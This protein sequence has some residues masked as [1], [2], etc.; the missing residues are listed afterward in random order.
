M[1]KI[2][3]IRK[4]FVEKYKTLQLSD[5]ITDTI[6]IIG[7]QFIADAS[8]IFGNVNE[9]YLT[10]EIAW[11]K[12]QSL[13]VNDIP[14][15]P[16]IWTTVADPSGFINSNYG[17]CIFSS[18]NNYQYYNCLAELKENPN[19]RRATM[20]YNRPSMWD[21]YNKNGMS[22]FMC[23]YSTQYFIRD[24]KLVT[25]VFMRSNDSIFG[26]KND[27]G[28]QTY[29]S[30][31][32]VKDLKGTYPLIE[33]EPIIWHAGNLHIYPRHYKLVEDYIKENNL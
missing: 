2:E 7:A 26:F 5:T 33:M 16:K 15:T 3:D 23:T 28:W 1:N 14:N 22:D 4:I 19:S 29:V 25:L 12:S 20:I 10:N 8:T 24:N 11:Y 18:D 21:D 27:L 6:E 13:N 31:K 30:N 32:L 17:W 9:N